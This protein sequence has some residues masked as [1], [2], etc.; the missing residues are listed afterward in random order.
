MT[1]TTIFVSM[2]LKKVDKWDCFVNVVSGFVVI[3]VTGASGYL[4]A[5]IV[6]QLLGKAIASKRACT[7]SSRM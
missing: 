7:Y 2:L 3:Q 6:D 1:I 5:H 4:G